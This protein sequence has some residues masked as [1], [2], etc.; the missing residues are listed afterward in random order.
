MALTWFVVACGSPTQPRPEP[1]P[2]ID[3]STQEPPTDVTDAGGN[4]PDAALPPS[5]FAELIKRQL[6]ASAAYAQRDCACFFAF[7]GYASEESC[8]HDADLYTEEQR[9]CVASVYASHPRFEATATCAANAV[10]ARTECIGSS[11]DDSVWQDCAEAHDPKSCPSLCEDA[12]DPEECDAELSLLF[13][14]RN[15]CS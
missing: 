8:V 7:N 1:E 12:V 14:T 3:A 5:P 10:I 4:D 15:D 2:E 9:E 11:C 6:D 13:R